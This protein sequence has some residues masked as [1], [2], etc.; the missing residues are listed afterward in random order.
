MFF[1]PYATTEKI[2]CTFCEYMNIVSVC[3]LE[4]GL[5]L[6]SEN[7]RENDANEGITQTNSLLH[8]NKVADNKLKLDQVQWCAFFITVLLLSLLFNCRSLAVCFQVTPFKYVILL[9]HTAHVHSIS[10]SF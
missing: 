2:G 6:I 10:I 3:N 1:L 8:T 9:V 7:K 4:N 5:L